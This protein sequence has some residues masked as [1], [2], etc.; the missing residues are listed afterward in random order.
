MEATVGT[1]AE[2]VRTRWSKG[3][4]SASEPGELTEP[5][6]SESVRQ[7]HRADLGPVYLQAGVPPP[8]TSRQVSHTASTQPFGAH[9]IPARSWVSVSKCFQRQDRET[10]YICK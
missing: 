1:L 7:T 5:P 4:H 3:C 2:N 8:R 6:R 10:D 9:S